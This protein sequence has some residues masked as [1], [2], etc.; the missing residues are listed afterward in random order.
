[1]EENS[2]IRD[3]IVDS[4]SVS[5]DGS[6]T[7]DLSSGISFSDPESVGSTLSDVILDKDI[8]NWI[9]VSNEGMELSPKYDVKVL[10]SENDNEEIEESIVQFFDSLGEGYGLLSITS[11][12]NS[13]KWRGSPYT[14]F[15]LVGLLLIILFTIAT[16]TYF[17]TFIVLAV[18]TLAYAVLDFPLYRKHMESYAL[19]EMTELLSVLLEHIE[20]KAL[21]SGII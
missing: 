18:Y 14:V 10:V 8:S 2:R 11:G 5:A 7:Y 9:S 1:M 6:V 3:Q 21:D 15:Y 16:I 4:R 13:R 17:L 20:V 12:M 19:D